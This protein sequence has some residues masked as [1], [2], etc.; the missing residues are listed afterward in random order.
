ML[1]QTQS[2]AIRPIT[3]AHLAQ[4]MSLLELSSDELRQKIEAEL[5]TNPALELADEPR[6]PHCGKPL[7]APGVCPICSAPRGLSVEQPIVFVSPRRDFTP[8]SDGYADE[9]TSPEEWTPAVEELPTYVLR[10]IAPELDPEDRPLAAHILT[11]LDEDGLLSVPLVEIARYHHVPLDRV[12]KV[13]SLIQRADPL[14]VGSPTP[15]AAL[16]IQ[17]EVLAETRH[18]PAQAAKA[19]QQ[20]M[21]LLSRRAYAELGRLLKISTSQ[22]THIARF[23]S[24]NLNPFPARACWGEQHTGGKPPQVYYQ[25]D[26]IINR[27]RNEL[28]TPLVVEVVSPFAGSLRVNPLF[29]QALSQAPSDKIEH[30]QSDLDDATLLV[31]CLQQRNNTLVR[32]MQMLVV[33]QRR[34]ILE[35]DAHLVPLTRAHIADELDVHESTISR[36]VASKALQLPNNRIIPLAKLFDRSLHIRTALL[37]II[38]E[39]EK[40]LSDAQIANLLKAQGYPVARRTVAKYRSMEGILPARLRRRN[41]RKNVHE[42]A[43][44]TENVRRTEDVRPTEN[45]RQTEDIRR[46]GKTRRA[47]TIQANPMPTLP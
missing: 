44:R 17:L 1:L 2:P 26:V 42:E 46:T 24:E 28:D 10:Q 38:A 7:P 45:V 40:P 36:A 32:L 4:T 33:L 23:I 18:V 8:T 5:S 31:K 39:E 15:Q 22:A 27:L 34:F 47:K 37:Q 29:R 11:S 3:T 41:T 14:G 19:I 13:L 6:C 9:E 30:W 25:A 12:E 21:D 20:G 16:L 35:G 43:R